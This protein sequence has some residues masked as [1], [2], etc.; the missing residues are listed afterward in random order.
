[1]SN[2]VGKSPYFRFFS[3]KS[4]DFINIHEYYKMI[5]CIFDH[6]VNIIY[7]SIDLRR[8]IRLGHYFLLIFQNWLLLKE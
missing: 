7:L 5:I 6:S 4:H 8:V 1:M 2:F 3:L